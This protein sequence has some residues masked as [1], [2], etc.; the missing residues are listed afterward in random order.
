MFSIETESYKRGVPTT[1]QRVDEWSDL[2]Q[3]TLAKIYIPGSHV[4][5]DECV[6]EYTARSTL[7]TTILNKSH[8]TGFKVWVIAERGLFLRWIWH[9][10]GKG[11]VGIAKRAATEI[12][13]NPTQQVVVH[14]ASL[15]PRL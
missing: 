15:L 12:H 14:L 6:M 1:Y 11:P 10:L 3:D 4:A 2:Q 9:M 8:P 5:V 7:T 13:L